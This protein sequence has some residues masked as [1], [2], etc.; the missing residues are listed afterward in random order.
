V[1]RLAEYLDTLDAPRLMDDEIALIDEAV[2]KEHH[3]RYVRRI[4]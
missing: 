2:A 3:R 4:T 1:S